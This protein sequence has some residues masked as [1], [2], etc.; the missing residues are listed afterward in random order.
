M[1]GRILYLDNIR[2]FLISYVIAGHVSVAY[3]AL[4]GGNWYYIEPAQGFAT[5]AAFYL[6][7]MLAYSF[8]MAMFIFISGY[9]TPASLE[10]KGSLGFLKDRI[11]RLFIPLYCIIFFWDRLPAISACWPKATKA[12]F[13]N[14]GKG[15]INRVFTA[16]R[17]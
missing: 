2:I 6:F 9:F 11:F 1:K 15:C 13:S 12:A 3:G 17:G 7:D 14:S 10:R 4:G 5:K 8:L 16:I